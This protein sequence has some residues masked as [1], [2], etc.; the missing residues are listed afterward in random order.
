MKKLF[1]Y[2][3]LI[4]SSNNIIDST[5]AMEKKQIYHSSNEKAF[6]NAR[7]LM[8]EAQAKRRSRS[9]TDVQKISTQHRANSV[10]N[11]S[12]SHASKAMPDQRSTIHE[13][14]L[15]KEIALEVRL[16]IA[17]YAFYNSQEQ[18]EEIKHFCTICDIINDKISR[19]TEINILVK[20]GLHVCAK[21]EQ[22]K[23]TNH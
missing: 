3:S 15:E 2:L 19:N 7:K 23:K 11:K 1:L 9:Y 12:T 4:F 16:G 14:F 18:S 8:Q 20:Q 13:S 5:L 6:I 22:R 17:F 21:I 10:Q